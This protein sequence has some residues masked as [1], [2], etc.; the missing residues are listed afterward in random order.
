MPLNAKTALSAL[1]V[2]ALLATA[3]VASGADP[4]KGEFRTCSREMK[5]TDV[6]FSSRA[7]MGLTVVFDDIGCAVIWRNMQCAMDQTLFDDKATARDFDDLSTIRMSEAYYVLDDN[8]MTPIKFG[9]AAFRN[10]K[11]ARKY[12]VDNGSGKLLGYR[13]LIKLDLKPPVKDEED[14]E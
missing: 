13:D 1:L 7:D 9:I 12:M 10:I 11:A 6:R 8:L 4:E 2:A 3:P 14:E 5:I